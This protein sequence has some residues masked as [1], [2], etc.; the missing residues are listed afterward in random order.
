MPTQG[1]QL[2]QLWSLLI[3]GG[4]P[5]RAKTA[6]DSSKSCKHGIAVHAQR[7]QNLNIFVMH[8][9]EDNPFKMFISYFCKK[10]QMKEIAVLHS[11]TRTK[12]QHSN[13]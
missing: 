10:I 13:L 4:T 8:V 5:P 6:T 2:T 12:N 1:K 7:F 3:A 9:F 11:Q